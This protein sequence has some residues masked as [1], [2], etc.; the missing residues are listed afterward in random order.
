MSVKEPPIDQADGERNRKIDTS[1][2]RGL[3]A[4]LELNRRDAMSARELS[5]HLDV[6]RTSARRILDTLAA[7]EFVEK[8]PFDARYRLNPHVAALSS[9][10]S[11]AH[12]LSHAAAPL[13]FEATR[14][15]DWS[16]AL[17]TM[18]E[19]DTVL[20]VSTAREAR[21]AITFFKVGFKVPLFTSKAGKVMLAYLSEA[22][23]GALAARDAPIARVD[24][25]G[26]GDLDRIRRDGFYAPP[27]EIGSRESH[28]YVPVFIGERAP[29]CLIMRYFVSALPRSELLERFTPLLKRVSAEITERATTP[30]VD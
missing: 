16:L 21:H 22:E 27:A 13:L 11:E 6:P 4:L 8:V 29:A 18:A 19:R 12:V 14:Q 24:L 23:R 26:T 28:L 10:L 9:G 7:A 30:E 25:G 20:Q 5:R 2:Y 15:I 17:V 3:M 1:L